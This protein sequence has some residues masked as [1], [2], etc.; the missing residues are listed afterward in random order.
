VKLCKHSLEN[1]KASEAIA[2]FLGS[3]A[4][5]DAETRAR[6]I[7]V[8]IV[9]AMDWWYAKSSLSSR[10][11]KLCDT[12]ELHRP[13]IACLIE[14]DEQWNRYPLPSARK[15]EAV[16]GM[17][18]ATLAFASDIFE[19]LQTIEDV[20]IPSQISGDE[21]PKS[22]SVAFLRHRESGSLYLVI[23]VHLESGPPSTSEKIQMRWD[24]MNDTLSFISSKLIKPLKSR[25]LEFSVLLC[26]DFNAVRE[27]FLHGN[28]PDFCATGIAKKAQ[29]AK[30]AAGLDAYLPEKRCFGA[31]VTDEG[32]LQLELDGVEGGWLEEAYNPDVV[33]TRAGQPVVIDFIM[34][35][36]VG[37][38]PRIQ[39]KPL[40][41]SSAADQ[42]AA[43]DFHGGVAAAVNAVG[44][45]HL[46]I[47]CEFVV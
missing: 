12:F 11:K 47:A 5:A 40:T 37:N 24:Q 2:R 29:F 30:P 4:P 35:G 15:Y 44:S 16:R 39:P 34:T 19:S 31:K 8:E 1:V 6:L 27:E 20:E 9:A 41:I 23:G 14:F 21:E 28:G 32:A 25:S 38:L 26:G 3:E 33:C 13:D 46:P 7:F 45:D 22:S 42:E 17:G 18:K 10:Y 43:A 36:T